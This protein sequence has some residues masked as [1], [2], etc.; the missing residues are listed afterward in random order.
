MLTMPLPAQRSAAG[1]S[2]ACDSPAG[3]PRSSG[4][5]VLYPDALLLFGRRG[6]L[7]HRDIY[8]GGKQE[9]GGRDRIAVLE[10]KLLSYVSDWFPPKTELNRERCV[11]LERCM[12]QGKRQP[13]GLF[14]LT[15]PTGDGK[16]VA[17]LA[18]A[19]RHA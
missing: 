9:R 4:D 5:D 18:F 15:I 1:S 11:M 12:E 7:G 17:S 10:G 6:F 19:L 13:M 2:A 16:T 14:T 3:I 8:G